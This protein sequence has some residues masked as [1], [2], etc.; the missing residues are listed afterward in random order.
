MF[1]PYIGIFKFIMSL[2][3]VAIHVQPFSDNMAFYYNN[4][5]ARIA[6]PMFFTLSSYFL[7]NKLI[8]SNWDKNIFLKHIQHLLHYY[9]IWLLVFSPIIITRTWQRTNNIFAF[10][11]DIFKQ[12]FLSGTYGALWF[13]PALLLG[14]ALTYVIGKKSTP[15]VC[16]AISFPFFLFTVFEM[17][18]TLLIQDISWLSAINNFFISIFGWLGNGVNYGFF[19]CSLGLYIAS[20]KK[21]VQRKQ[22]KDLIMVILSSALL[23]LECT[24]I[25]K[26]NLGVSY[27]AMFFL[28]PVT[29][30]LIHLLLEL[31]SKTKHN[32]VP[33]ARYLQNMSLLIFPLHYGIM[34]M[35]E[36]ILK[37]VKWYVASTTIQYATVIVI[38]CAI[39]A[40]IMTLGKKHKILRYFYGK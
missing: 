21:Q 31:Q 37:D 11:C 19:F 29:Y 23:V 13:L 6:D 27:G 24:I 10:L 17:E 18:Y 39:S 3:V 32:I 9:F 22:N 2:F 4:C 12:I 26:F 28:I 15:K 8:N 33:I 40:L 20:Q 35:L 5:I 30:Y 25:R 1:N 34:E 36:Y 16:L 7:F 14:L 38:T